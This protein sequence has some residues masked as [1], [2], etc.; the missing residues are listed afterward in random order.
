MRGG[1]Q[2]AESVIELIDQLEDMVAGSRRLPLSTSVVLNEDDL[3]ELVDRIRLAIPDELV[4]ARHTLDDSQRIMTGAEEESERL[5]GR[6]DQEAERVVREAREQSAVL[7]SQH[8]IVSQAQ[9]QADALLS[10]AEEHAATVHRDAD[11]YAREVMSH[12][13]EQMTHQLAT[14]RRGLETLP[15]A[16]AGRKRR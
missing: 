14:I 12:L 1:M 9:A 3:L 2:V 8:H 7:V 5:L 11:A 16:P 13:E 6:A 4:S 10:A 15:R